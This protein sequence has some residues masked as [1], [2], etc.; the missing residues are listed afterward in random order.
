M[1]RCISRPARRAGRSARAGVTL[2]E[3]LIAITLLSLL[4]TGVLVA[5]RLGFGTMEKTDAYLSENR[6]VVN[7]RR[8]VESE[9]NGFILTSAYFYP[10]PTAYVAV[11]FLQAEPQ[12]MRF[13]TTYSLNE[14]LRGRPQIAEMQVISGEKGEGVRLILNETPYTGPVQAGLRVSGLEPDPSGRTLA[15][16]QLIQAGTGSFV[17]ADRLAY[18]R[19]SYLELQ[20]QAPFQLW[21]P[22]WTLQEKLPLGVRIEMAPL[23]GSGTRL[24]V[25]SVTVPLRV[26][27]NP[28]TGTIYAD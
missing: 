19:F 3:I 14:G 10:Q 26:D 22:A 7:A 25:T 28:A 1:S 24:H 11:P 13:V 20:L 12:S 16:Y 23:D 5:M 17:L 4:A 8:I 18:C 2:I 21:R 15:H 27:R 6:R 9:I